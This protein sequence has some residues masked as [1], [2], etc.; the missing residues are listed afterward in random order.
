MLKTLHCDCVVQAVHFHTGV[1]VNY[2]GLETLLQSFK[3]K[4]HF[5]IIK[6]SS[7]LLSKLFPAVHRN[8]NLP[9]SHES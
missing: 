5:H 2:I 3:S 9:N 6:P 8:T 1:T 7:R 4:V